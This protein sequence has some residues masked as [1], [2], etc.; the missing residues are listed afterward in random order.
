MVNEKLN[1]QNVVVLTKKLFHAYFSGDPEPWFA[2]LCN[3]S[4]WIGHGEPTLFGAAAIRERF[5]EV[6]GHRSTIIR[7]E[8]FP[9]QIKDNT[10]IICGQFV[11]GGPGNSLEYTIYYTMYYSMVG[12][13][14]KIMHQHMSHDFI[15][16]EED[17]S[18]VYNMDR[19]YYLFIK[20][21]L[22]EQ[23]TVRRITIQSSRQSMFVDPFSILYIHSQGKKT[24]VYCVDRVISCNTPIG[25]LA[26]MLPEEF[27]QVHRGYIINTLYV[28]GLKR[29]EVSLVSGVTIPI[30]AQKYMQ[31]K[32]VLCKM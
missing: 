3:Q 19:T 18:K 13:E 26:E 12:Q 32:K 28:T 15:R 8:H 4:V 9:V 17:H 10:A 29:Y 14:L 11:I 27:Y 16:T 2:R 7:E 5:Q 24:E 1:E 30:P 20:K 23:R 21:L 25:E 6:T 31:V 22:L